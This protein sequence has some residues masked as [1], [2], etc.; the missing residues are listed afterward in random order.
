MKRTGRN[1][2]IL[3]HGMTSR[4][5]CRRHPGR[6]EGSSSSQARLS[7]RRMTIPRFARNDITLV[8]DAGVDAKRDPAVFSIFRQI[9]VP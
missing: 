8:A 3:P 6:S 2:R 4:P 9:V 1:G 7:Y 5:T